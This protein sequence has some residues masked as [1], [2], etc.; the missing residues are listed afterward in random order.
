M[1]KPKR[2]NIAGQK[3]TGTIKAAKGNCG[4]G[5]EVGDTFNL[6]CYDTG[7]LC[8]LLYY[9]VYPTLVM[10]QF[11]GHYPWGNPDSFSFECMDRGNAVTI[12]L[13]REKQNP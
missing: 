2:P 9:Q 4:W 5:H 11:G 3:I 1:A 12:E 8:G 13:R 7:G 10:L 6:S